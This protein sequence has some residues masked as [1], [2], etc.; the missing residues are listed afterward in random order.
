MKRDALTKEQNTFSV[1]LSLRSA[2][3][4]PFQLSNQGRLQ[5]RW[6]GQRPA[7]APDFLSHPGPS[8]RP[9]LR[10]LC[11]QLCRAASSTES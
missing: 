11:C 2:G 7:T 10:L 5:G 3:A 6:A 4:G 9:R 1:L 8:S